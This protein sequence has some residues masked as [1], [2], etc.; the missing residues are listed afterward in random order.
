MKSSYFVVG[1]SAK[2]L[3][4]QWRNELNYLP[5]CVLVAVDFGGASIKNQVYLDPPTEDLIRLDLTL[6]GLPITAANLAAALGRNAVFAL[7]EQLVELAASGESTGAEAACACI[8]NAVC[9]QASQYPINRPDR[10]RP[11][12]RG[13]S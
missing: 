3:V 12:E 9:G 2:A 5:P 7:A 11:H 6:F 10:R 8:T 4:L 13:P 1:R